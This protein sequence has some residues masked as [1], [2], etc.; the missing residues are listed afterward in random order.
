MARY[1]ELE[2]LSLSENRVLQQRALGQILQHAYESTAFYRRRFD[3]AGVHPSDISLP[4]DLER[5]PPL[6]RDD[7]REN[8]TELQSNRFSPQD[9]TQAAT[10]GT[11][12]T[13]VALR[14]NLDSVREKVAILW[15]FNQWAGYRPGDKVF[16]LW[17]ARQD[18]NE[19][20]SWRWRLYDHHLMRHVWA[21]TSLLNDT[22]LESYRQMMNEFRPRIVYAYPTPLALFCEYLKSCGRPCHQPVSAICTAEP[23]LPSQRRIIEEM[24]CPVFERY[25][26]REFGMIAA[27]CE[28]HRGMHLNT[29]A[30]YIEFVPV[31]G[32]EVEGL[33]E[34]LAT[35]LLN[36]GMPLIRYRINDCVVPRMEPC[37]CGRGLPLL[38]TIE[39]RTGDV[40][41][42]PNGDAVPGVALTNR[43]LKVCPGLKKTQVVQETLNDLRV[44]YVPGPG[45]DPSQLEVLKTGLRR[46]FPEQ[47]GLTFE[48]VAD[49][50]R[51]RSGK[52][53]FCISNVVPP[54][55]PCLL[56]GKGRSA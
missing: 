4:S 32:A 9:L 1:R 27:E 26:S 46:F 16:H 18:Y 11:T 50:E 37:S 8:L 53:R 52:T 15:Q 7:I 39:G 48:K 34:I 19:N 55:G 31:P 17:G 43:V 47:V 36:Y 10:G 40:F 49:I 35:D 25:G 21:P 51:E 13:P 45:F 33:H 5:I 41:Y 28:H 12:D 54:A 38:G 29:A 14:R 23:L 44:R 24:L 6:T 22:V 30:V 3:E 20:P 42:L 56:A 2:R